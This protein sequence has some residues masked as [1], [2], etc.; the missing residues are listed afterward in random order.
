AALLLLTVLATASTTLQTT[1][2]ASVSLFSWVIL[3]GPLE[4]L[5]F[6]WTEPAR[7]NRALHHLMAM[8]VTV[9]PRPA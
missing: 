1:V 3:W 5:L 4:A 6:D 9:D 2:M 8:D 7:A